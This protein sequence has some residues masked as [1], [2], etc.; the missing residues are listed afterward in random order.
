META[1][2]NQ[3]GAYVTSDAHGGRL[4]TRS[5]IPKDR[6]K[7]AACIFLVHG[8]NEH[9]GRYDDMAHS[10]TRQG[11]AVFGHDQWGHGLSG[12]FKGD[13]ENLNYLIKDLKQLIR[14]QRQSHP[15]VPF[16]IVAHSMGTIVGFHAAYEL[17]IESPSFL[18][19]IIFSGCALVPGPSAA[20]PFGLRCLFALTKSEWASG[21]IGGFMAKID[22][23]GPLAPVIESEL[24]RDLV[25]ID[26]IKDD[27]LHNRGPLLNR[28]GNQILLKCREMKERLPHFTMPFL[29]MHGAAD[30]ITLPEGTQILFDHAGST[31]KTL[32]FYPGLFHELFL[33]IPEARTMVLGDV[34]A[35]LSDIVYKKNDSLLLQQQQ[36]LGGAPGAGKDVKEQTWVE[37]GKEGRREVAE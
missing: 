5:W 13:V 35:F 8:V 36:G 21:A 23:R 28:T 10:L 19:G 27:P 29:A 1:W 24:T 7:P 32:K 9:V 33:E 2:D 34:H 6:V 3:H 15:E 14:A 22:P 25:E 17:S 26:V 31:V 20:S 16:F 12:G 11:Y 4:F 37:K 18:D 30:T